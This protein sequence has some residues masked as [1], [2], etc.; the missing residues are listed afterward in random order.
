MMVTPQHWVDVPWTLADASE[1]IES[2]AKAALA[3]SGGGASTTG[4]GLNIPTNPL[5]GLPIDPRTYSPSSAAVDNGWFGTGLLKGFNPW[6]AWRGLVQG[7][8]VNLH[9]FLEQS[10]GITSNSYGLAIMLFTFGLRTLTLPL[11]YLTFAATERTK[12][13]QV[14]TRSYPPDQR[15]PPTLLQIVSNTLPTLLH[16][17]HHGRNQRTV[18]RPRNAKPSRRKVVSCLAGVKSRVCHTLLALALHVACLPSSPHCQPPFPQPT[19]S[20]S[21]MQPQF[22]SHVSY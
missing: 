4:G 16:S 10:C 3:Q 22:F 20:P 17:A 12:A 18:S 7:S 5:T 13:M 6:G 9:D 14:I 8:I 15:R 19:S 11:T 21:P 2:S 1:A